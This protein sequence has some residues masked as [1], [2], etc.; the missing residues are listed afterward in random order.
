VAGDGTVVDLRGPLGDRHDL[1]EVAA[2]ACA[3]FCVSVGG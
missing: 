1:A 3:F 2:R